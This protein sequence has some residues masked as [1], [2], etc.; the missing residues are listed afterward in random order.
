[1]PHDRIYDC[2]FYVARLLNDTD[3]LADEEGSGVSIEGPTG[4]FWVCA[5]D[6]LR[7]VDT[8]YNGVWQQRMVKSLPERAAPYKALPTDELDALL[9]VGLCVDAGLE[10]LVILAVRCSRPDLAG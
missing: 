5:W 9:R 2:N 4:P 1:M 7:E 3:A 10:T 8:I 6:R